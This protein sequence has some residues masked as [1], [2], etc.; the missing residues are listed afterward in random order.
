MNKSI[1]LALKWPSNENQYL[2]LYFSVFLLSVA[3][4]LT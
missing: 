3:E 2:D 1:S 4:I